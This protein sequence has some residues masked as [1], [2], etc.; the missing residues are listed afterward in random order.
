MAR[1]KK[2]KAPRRRDK[3]ISITGMA[4][5][6]LLANVGT[7]AAFNMN[8]WDWV[9]DGWGSAS[10]ATQAGQL[11]LYELIYGNY[12]GALASVATAGAGSSG[13]AVAPIGGSGYTP[14]IGLVG[15]SNADVV[16]S[17]I[18]NNWMPALIQSVAIPVSFR[19]GKKLLRRPITMGNKL[20]KQAG[21]RSMVKI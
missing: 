3:A 14:R 5:S 2:S 20:L 17:N 8:A 18:Q 16:L 12:G 13:S 11:S 1:R 4:E 10:T 21:L 6:I 19:V 9:K 7:Q 15:G